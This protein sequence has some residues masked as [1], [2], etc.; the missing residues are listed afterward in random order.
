M[1]TGKSIVMAKVRKTAE[2]RNFSFW[3]RESM[4]TT[5]REVGRSPSVS[6]SSMEESTCL[7]MLGEGWRRAR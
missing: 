7:V 1:K 4:P 3:K 6:S 2:A 5:L